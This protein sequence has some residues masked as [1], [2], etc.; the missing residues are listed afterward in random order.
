MLAVVSAITLYANLEQRVIKVTAPWG[1]WLLHALGFPEPYHSAI[2]TA[3]FVMGLASIL[4]LAY[5]PLSWRKQIE[6]INYF[7]QSSDE[8]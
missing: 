4:F 1:S 6:S 5:A 8:E 3:T 7:G 2:F